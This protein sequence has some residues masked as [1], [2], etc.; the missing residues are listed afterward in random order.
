MKNRGNIRRRRLWIA[1]VEPVMKAKLTQEQRT[2]GQS[3]DAAR[4]KEEEPEDLEE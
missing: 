3:I 2:A 4:E 1:D